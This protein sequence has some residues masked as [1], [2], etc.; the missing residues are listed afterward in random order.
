MIVVCVWV[1]SSCV[2]PN[3]N[4]MHNWI[5][6][7]QPAPVFVALLRIFCPF[8]LQRVF[9]VCELLKVYYHSF[10]KF[11]YK[12]D[13]FNHFFC[14]L[15][16][17]SRKWPLPTRNIGISLLI[18]PQA[19][20]LKNFQSRYLATNKQKHLRVEKCNHQIECIEIGCNS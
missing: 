9:T 2:F 20:D 11:Y 14:S 3:N 8:R 13:W 7:S 19:M 15:G 18:S 1:F 12:P 17:G 5:T 10:R 4:L 6:W 16:D